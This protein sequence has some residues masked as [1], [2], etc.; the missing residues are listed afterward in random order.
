MRS[1]RLPMAVVVVLLLVA[2]GARADPI[3]D[4]EKAHSAYV[5]HK[6]ADAEARLRALLDPATGDL[7]DPDNIADARMYL[8]A[9]LVEEG[10][11]SEAG[12]VFEKL[13]L[14]KPDYAPDPLRVSIDATHAV[15][16]A[17]SRL[18]D[19]LQRVQAERVQR[20]QAD[21]AKAE[22]VRQR[23]AQRQ[24]MLEKLAGEERVVDRSSR[25]KALL[26]FGVG[27]FQNGQDG[28]GWVFL[29]A[30]ALLAVSSAV[31]AAVS[32]YDGSQQANAT[33][34][35]DEET[36]QVYNENART[37]AYVDLALA[38]GFLLT[39]IAGAVH[40]ELTFVPEHVTVR[41]RELPRLSIV[42]IVGPSGIGLAGRF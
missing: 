21:K 6:Y 14:D 34:R 22:L 23:E 42:P 4:L 41:K 10:K 19:I 20:E 32:V 3:G 8:A 38:G 2:R 11:R 39:A 24:A 25:W 36:A 29:S 1:R 27:Q 26:P 15:F 7:K 33:A 35:Q 37:A 31:A 12:E 16:V 40:A 28:A 17:R 18:H 13:L 30:E 9:I 5:A